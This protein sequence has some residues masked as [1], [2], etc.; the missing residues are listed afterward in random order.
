MKESQTYQD[1]STK[2]EAIIRSLD[3]EKID[4]DIM[5]NKVEEG[6]KLLDQMRGK[7]QKS[8]ERIDQLKSDYEKEE[9]NPSRYLIL[10]HCQALPF[11]DFQKTSSCRILYKLVSMDS[12]RPNFYDC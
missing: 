3:N 8:Q 2:V 11:L 5:L 4:L 12:H 10:D 6:Y 9:N 7:L 1:M